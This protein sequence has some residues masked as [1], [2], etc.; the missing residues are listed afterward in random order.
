MLASTLQAAAAE[1]GIAVR[2]CPAPAGE[3][4]SLAFAVKV[5]GTDC[6]VYLAKVAPRDAQ[7][8][9]KA[10]DDKRNSAE[11]FETA[12]FATFD[13]RG[14]VRVTVT[15]PEGFDEGHSVADV[16]F[17]SVLVNG[18]PLAPAGIDANASVRKVVVRP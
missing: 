8:R 11:Y 18:M 6:P 1:S 7:R 5:E 14:T 13:M 9:W 12:S 16:T 4:R 17:E 3:Q 10:M 15:C 2:I